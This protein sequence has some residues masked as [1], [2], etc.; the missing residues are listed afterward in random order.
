MGWRVPLLAGPE[1][2]RT[3]G[4]C[5]WDPQGGAKGP[6]LPGTWG[7]PCENR[8]C[9][10]EAR[11]AGHPPSRV[12]GGQTDSRWALT[13]R[14][15]GKT[16]GWATARAAEQ[17]WALQGRR[18]RLQG[19]GGTPYPKFRTWARTTAST[20][21]CPSRKA[22]R[23]EVPSSW[24]SGLARAWVGGGER[25]GGQPGIRKRRAFQLHGKAGLR[26]S[27]HTP[28]HQAGR[29]ETEAGHVAWM[30]SSP[31]APGASVPETGTCPRDPEGPHI[32]PIT[33][34]CGPGP[35]SPTRRD[36]PC[37]DHPSHTRRL[38]EPLPIRKK[39]EGLPGPQ[40]RS[41]K[42]RHPFLPRR[43]PLAGTSASPCRRTLS[44]SLALW[45]LLGPATLTPQEVTSSSFPSGH[46]GTWWGSF[47]G[48]CCLPPLALWSDAQLGGRPGLTRILQTGEA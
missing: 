42:P 14:K 46:P 23:G 16:L 31:C 27:S 34:S 15:E 48:P 40:K 2:R 13:Y 33:T 37:S 25:A 12:P 47:W 22:W 6:G 4:P 26:D 32:S 8:N 17:G 20:E 10:G 39:Q 36:A 11:P 1:E 9:P 21:R 7:F 19:P 38:L 35:S 18:P 3:R 5:S 43:T 28:V 24:W 45:S 29:A 30:H 41:H 44:E